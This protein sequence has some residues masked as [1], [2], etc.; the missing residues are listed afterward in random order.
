MDGY[1]CFAS[2]FVGMSVSV[3]VTYRC[4]CVSFLAFVCVHT[5][6]HVYMCI[7]SYTYINNMWYFSL[8]IHVEAHV[9]GPIGFACSMDVDLTQ[10]IC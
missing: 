8:Y 9:H 2:K 1:I 3:P 6:T 5:N 7:Y 4:L 10:R